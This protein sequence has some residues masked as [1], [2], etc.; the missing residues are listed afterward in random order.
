MRKKKRSNVLIVERTISCPTALRRSKRERVTVEVIQ[1]KDI[2]AVAVISA[3]AEVVEVH[4]TAVAVKRVP[5]SPIGARDR[6][7]KESPILSV[8][9]VFTQQAAR[10]RDHPTTSQ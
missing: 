9:E 3:G 7:A 6:G 8:E 1:I 5:A 10:R 2:E 4:T